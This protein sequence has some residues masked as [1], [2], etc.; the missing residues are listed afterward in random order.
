MPFVV[1]MGRYIEFIT[2]YPRYRYYWQFGIASYRRQGQFSIWRIKFKIATLTLKALE[3]GLPPYLAQQLCPYAPTR[4]L[5]SST[6]KLLQVP[7]TNFRF[8]SCSFRVSAPTL[9]NSLPHIVRFCESLTTS[10]KHLKAFYFQSAFSG[11]LQ[12]PTTPV[13]LIHFLAFYKF[14]YLLTQPPLDYCCCVLINGVSPCW[15][16]APNVGFASDATFSV[17]FFPGAP[18]VT[19]CSVGVARVVGPGC[20]SSVN[21]ALRTQVQAHHQFMP[22]NIHHHYAR[23]FILVIMQSWTWV[24]FI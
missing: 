22:I 6:S 2:I 11:A 18:V 14:T 3:T 4:A 10:R 19:S 13:P 21:T 12:R 1:V 17:I 20:L 8:G 24:T 15:W 7:C 23:L 9:W 5:R 16:T